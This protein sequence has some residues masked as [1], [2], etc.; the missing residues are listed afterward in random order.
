MNSP[1]PTI[2]SGANR[3]D[4]CQVVLYTGL[5]TKN[6]NKIQEAGQD[7]LP[8]L[9]YVTDPKTNGIYK[10]ASLIQH[11][12]IPCTGTYGA[13]FLEGVGKL[14]YL[15][16][17]TECSISEE[18][19]NMLYDVIKDSFEPLMYKGLVMDMVNGRSIARSNW[20]DIENGEKVVKS[21]VKYFIPAAT[22]KE[23][24][25][26]KGVVKYW[27]ESNKD[28]DIVKNTN[29]LEYRA[30]LIDILNDDSV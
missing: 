18:K 21:I 11:D 15:L 6:D 10:D 30:M 19:V 13:I 4:M 24:S 22:S 2:S 16:D 26:L 20:Q 23:S 9:K 27:V 29:D 1:T 14:N 25:I 8:E 12:S 28:T 5:L 17:K 7:L 3:V